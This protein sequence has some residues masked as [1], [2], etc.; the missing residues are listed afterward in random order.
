MRRVWVLVLAAVALWGFVGVAPAAAARPAATAPLFC[1][2]IEPG[3]TSP[4]AGSCAPRNALR[5]Y[6]IDYTISGVQVLGW[7]VPSNVGAVGCAAGWSFCN[8]QENSRT[9]DQTF[10]V[11]VYYQLIAHASPLPAVTFSSSATAFIP[12]VCGAAFC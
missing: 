10:T 8:L 5:S 12:A 9:F 3:G 2:F 11:T 1:Q 7:T 4:H 6:T